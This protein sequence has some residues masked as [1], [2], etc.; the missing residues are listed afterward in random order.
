M[1]KFIELSPETQFLIVDESQSVRDALSMALKAM[2]L[3]RICHATD[4]AT[5][6]H[7]L[8]SERIDFIICDR[9]LRQVSGME[10]LKEIR[11][12]TQL[13]SMPFLM[14][15]SEISKEDVMLASEFGIDGYMQ[16]PFV[17]KEVSQ[18]VS[19][20]IGRHTDPANSEKQFDR[21]RQLYS[22]GKFEDSLNLYQQ[23]QIKFPDSARTRVGVAR[24]LRALD[25]IDQA[26]ESL[27]EAI[28]K[29]NLYVHAHHEL[30]LIY[31][32]LDD[33]ER[34]LEAFDQ[35]IA[36]SP[37]NPIRYET[38]SEIL[39]REKRYER[40]E[41]Y[42]MRAVK[43]ELVY[44]NIFS[45]LGKVLFAQ[46]KMDRAIKYFE[47][48]LQTQ[49][50]NTSFLNSLGICLKEVGRYED[51]L[52]YYNTALKYRQADTKVLYN[53]ALCLIQMND[54]D[55]ARKTLKAIVAIDPS[56]TKAIEK[57]EFLDSKNTAAAG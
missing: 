56:Y 36:A 21:A 52:K 24:C 57:L 45:Q 48:A 42:L 40:A 22:G 35:A 11:E 2:G 31:L 20:A 54:L 16:K 19:Q 9:N 47:Q 27:N 3:R 25:R 23:L 1:G 44:P 39:Y 13:M 4:A 5:A 51:A 46:K 43:L 30:A 55:R 15:S 34:S 29:N 53:K 18:K 14:L 10:L 41:E 49:P 38:I 33:I 8:Q 26:I 50:T 32:H 28:E 7:M 37:L 17:P 12:N 6:L